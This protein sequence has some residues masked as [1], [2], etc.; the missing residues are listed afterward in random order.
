MEGIVEPVIANTEIAR[1]LFPE[2]E[3]ISYREAVMAALQP[4][5]EVETRWSGALHATPA[6]EL[7]DREVLRENAIKLY[8]LGPR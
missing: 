2:V 3:P 1:R 7:S 6:Y 5:L 4:D 8:A